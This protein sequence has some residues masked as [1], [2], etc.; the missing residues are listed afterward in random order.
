MKRAQRKEES[1]L[2]LLSK[3]ADSLSDRLAS[4]IL[5]DNQEEIVTL[6]MCLNIVKQECTKH[7]GIKYFVIS[8]DE[9]PEPA[10]ENDGLIV[11]ISFLN[12]KRR[13]IFVDGIPNEY[14]IYTDQIDQKFKEFIGDK[15]SVTA[16]INFT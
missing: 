7:T 12:A 13:T 2:S 10:A 14:K 5:G 6:D 3:A 9:N 1:T 16:Q 15:D 11:T 8:V 4:A